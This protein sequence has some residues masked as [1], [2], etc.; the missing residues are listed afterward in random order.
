M[1]K[2]AQSSRLDGEAA[3]CEVCATRDA[4]VL[5]DEDNVR[6]CSVCDMTVHS[7][8]KVAQRHTRWPLCS[9]CH[10]LKATKTSTT[11]QQQG[12]DVCASCAGT[13]P[14]GKL[15][16]VMGSL[17][18]PALHAP[19]V[20]CVVPLENSEPL[21]DVQTTC[22]TQTGQQAWVRNA[23]LV[24]G[25]GI[26]P[27]V[28]APQAPPASGN[29]RVQAEA[30]GAVLGRASCGL[31]PA[32]LPDGGSETGPM[33]QADLAST[34]LQCRSAQAN[35]GGYGGGADTPDVLDMLFNSWGEEV[36]QAFEEQGVEGTAAAA[37][38]LDLS[39]WADSPADMARG[40]SQPAHMSFLEGAARGRSPYMCGRSDTGVL[41]HDDTATAAAVGAV[42]AGT[43]ELASHSTYPPLTVNQH[44]PVPAPVTQVEEQQC[45]R[46][47]RVAEVR[48][49]PPASA[50][51]Q[52]VG[53]T[54]QVEQPTGVATR[55]LGF[56]D[57]QHASEEVAYQ[58]QQQQYGQPQQDAVQSI[59]QQQQQ[60][61]CVQNRSQLA[62]ET[63]M[64]VNAQRSLVG[65]A[66]RD[67]QQPSP[68]SSRLHS[69]ASQAMECSQPATCPP[70]DMQPVAR[71][72][73]SALAFPGQAQ[74]QGQGQGQGQ[75]FS[76]ENPKQA[77]RSAGLQ[78]AGAM[79][80]PEVSQDGA[81]DAGAHMLPWLGSILSAQY[82]AGLIPEQQLAVNNFLGSKQDPP[83]GTVSGIGT[84]GSFGLPA[85]GLLAPSPRQSCD[86][87][88]M[89][90]SGTFSQPPQHHSFHMTAAT[91]MST[92]NGAGPAMGTFSLPY[93]GCV[94]FMPSIRADKGPSNP[95]YEAALL[96]AAGMVSPW[97][98]GL[99]PA[100][101]PVNTGGLQLPAGL[102]AAAAAGPLPLPLPLLGPIQTLASAAWAQAAAQS[103]GP[104]NG[105]AAGSGQASQAP[106]LSQ[107]QQIQASEE[108]AGDGQQYGSG[109]GSGGGAH[110]ANGL[111]YATSPL[112]ALVQAQQTPQQQTSQAKRGPTVQSQPQTSG[113]S[114]TQQQ[115][116][117]IKQ[118][119]S[120]SSAQA[121]SSHHQGPAAP[122]QNQ[123]YP[124]YTRPQ[125][126]NRASTNGHTLACPG[127]A[128][129]PA[130]APGPGQG[131][132]L[133]GGSLARDCGTNN[134]GHNAVPQPAASSQAKP[135]QQQQQSFPQPPS[136]HVR[137]QQ[138]PQHAQSLAH[139]V[140]QPQQQQQQ[141][142][143][144]G[145]RLSHSPQGFQQPSIHSL[146]QQQQQQQQQQQAPTAEQARGG[147]G[148]LGNNSNTSA[149]LLFN[150]Q[151]Q[152]Q[153]QQ[154][155]QLLLQSAGQ[156]PRNQQQLLM[157]LAQQQQQHL[158]PQSALLP[159][160]AGPSV[161]PDAFGSLLVGPM[162]QWLMMNMSHAASTGNGST[163]AANTVGGTALPLAMQLPPAAAVA[164]NSATA[165]AAAAAVAGLTNLPAA[166][167]LAT[168]RGPLPASMVAAAAS[169]V[170]AGP[171]PEASKVSRERDPRDRELAVHAERDE[172]LTRYRQK[173]KTR[174]FEK[175]I[176]YASRQIL[177]HKRPRIKGRFVKTQ[178][179]QAAIIGMSPATTHEPRTSEDPE[180]GDEADDEQEAEL[181]E[182]EEDDPLGA[183][184]PLR[185]A[186]G[187][188]M[189]LDGPAAAEGPQEAV[190]E[191][192]L[193]MELG[194]AGL[195]E[196]CDDGR[197]CRNSCDTME[198]DVSGGEAAYRMP[199]DSLC[200]G[201]SNGGG[202]GGGGAGGTTTGAGMCDR[203][204]AG[205]LCTAAAAGAVRGASIG[206]SND[207]ASS[208]NAAAGG[209]GGGF[210]ILGHSSALAATGGAHAG[211]HQ[212][213]HHPHHHY[214]G[215]RHYNHHHIGV[216]H[217]TALGQLGTHMGQLQHGMLGMGSGERLAPAGTMA[218]DEDGPALGPG[219][220]EGLR[221]LSD[222]D[223]QLSGPMP[224][225]AQAALS[226][227][228]HAQAQ[229]GISRGA[230]G[231][232][233]E[234][235]EE[236]VGPS[237]SVNSRL[238][239]GS[240]HTPGRRRALTGATGTVAAAA[241]EELGPRGG[242]HSHPHAHVHPQS[243]AHTHQ[244]EGG[245]F[246]GSAVPASCMGN[247]GMT[248]R[249]G[250]AA[251][252]ARGNGSGAAEADGTVS[253]N[254]ATKTGAVAVAKVNTKASRNCAAT[255]N[256]N[257]GNGSGN[258][259]CGLHVTKM[260]G[261]SITLAT[262][263]PTTVSPAAILSVP[264]PSALI[265]QTDVHLTNPAKSVLDA[266]DRQVQVFP[267]AQHLLHRQAQQHQQQH[268][269]TQ[270]PHPMLAPGPE[271]CNA[272]VD[273]TTAAAAVVGCSGGAGGPSGCGGGTGGARHSPRR[274]QTVAFGMPSCL[275]MPSTASCGGVSPLGVGGPVVAGCR[276]TP[277]PCCLVPD[278]ATD[279][280][281]P[282]CMSGGG[283]TEQ[284]SCMED[285]HTLV[286][287]ETA[288]GGAGDGEGDSECCSAEPLV[289]GASNTVPSVEASTHGQGQPRLRCRRSSPQLSVR[290]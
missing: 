36:G 30:G 168:S 216:G 249:Q 212:L 132:L 24:L 277:A 150:Q 276:G 15:H 175:T 238:S 128:P 190:A 83:S 102:M 282:C 151:Q 23:T 165:A 44:E 177:S 259:N 48:G 195:V 265:P 29:T 103:S 232:G 105:F 252:A 278:C 164:F 20:T 161:S 71:E 51:G 148:F 42:E 192:G 207:K 11:P 53:F 136:H 214:A 107:Q 1:K 54:P 19:Q 86:G 179:C 92:T 100:G 218:G 119:H 204:G 94:T 114:A 82:P 116:Q 180:A 89:L 241:Y 144:S 210:T 239:A 215:G 290:M 97:R 79:A 41:A 87:T 255:G 68:A 16:K 160:A 200:G 43:A 34:G 237:H 208:Q 3:N 110:A 242:A 262:A 234:E 98:P 99:L 224:A 137:P 121:T 267:A 191:G 146:W 56:D 9:V 280:A 139:G 27:P 57:K 12:V 113:L 6:L 75:P 4:T 185:E 69:N 257:C 145:A 50:Q 35:G 176:R 26:G 264:L 131:V 170:M 108:A 254:G 14:K 263:A 183:P 77:D 235:E 125:L 73:G 162:A 169:A 123:Q 159:P 230:Q 274:Q 270:A 286:D 38:D 287:A 46:T 18:A 166:S 147:L 40:P 268:A 266:S 154:L 117:P 143:V 49:S 47:Q 127:P 112:G 220:I 8:N 88:S 167:A 78:N 118:E 163:T 256:A 197:G 72:S 273:P 172:A 209:A 187:P 2:K 198:L 21:P 284:G 233:A 248:G 81:Q 219:G 189:D 223:M 63:A 65:S 67:P 76:H 261:A 281:A 205:T 245:A 22:G 217:L 231:G 188:I 153:L 193:G 55:S 95:L 70:R 115:Q 122:G 111:G 202:V 253:T 61:P 7:A 106:A 135:P 201:C 129:A 157:Q 196:A 10:R 236:A 213:H 152:Q 109:G 138:L 64:E 184:K 181:E 133:N 124:H 37:G 173:R 272:V 246:W 32:P 228:A 211:G 178:P 66:Y 101:L 288:G 225:H 240:V 194:T 269:T 279:A 258:G 199:R 85:V 84:S 45:Q 203:N 17:A 174:H 140:S 141:L 120:T 91:P 33:D 62:A 243:H 156:G 74:A 285:N 104:Y 126:A 227:S 59:L 186:G 260:G 31:S 250:G 226:G 251:G 60:P 229:P 142:H 5:C 39:I 247:G 275:P 149:L 90:V 222:M 271:A 171:A 283:T 221:L 134:S 28:G 93:S 244:H 155:Q 289:S 96:S 158:M 25:S 80:R 130:P 13:V 206:C 182:V 58:Q 52:D